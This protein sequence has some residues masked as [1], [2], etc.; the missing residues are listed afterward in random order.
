MIHEVRLSIKKQVCFTRQWPSQVKH[1]QNKIENNDLLRA[2]I[3][4][5]TLVSKQHE[6]PKHLQ[7][8]LEFSR[9]L[10]S[11]FCPGQKFSSIK[12]GNFQPDISFNTTHNQEIV[13]SNPARCWAFFLILLA[14]PTF[15]HQCSVVNEVASRRWILNVCC[16]MKKMDAYLCCL[17]QNSLCKLR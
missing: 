10:P 1:S 6:F 5:L 3:W 16:E 9:S 17:W 11:E 13:G 7:L 14:F 15:L 8:H 2:L 12:A 4:R